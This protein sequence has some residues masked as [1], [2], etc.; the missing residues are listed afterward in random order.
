MYPAIPHYALADAHEALKNLSD[1]YATR[2]VE[3][4]GTLFHGGSDLPTI[5][6]VVALPG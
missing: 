2:V 3:V 1:D 5:Q 6:D 4:H